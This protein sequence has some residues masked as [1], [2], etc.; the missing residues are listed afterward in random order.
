MKQFHDDV[1]NEIALCQTSFDFTQQYIFIDLQTPEM[2]QISHTK[3]LKVQ[4]VSF[5]AF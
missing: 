2:S 5:N 4:L 3:F 1:T